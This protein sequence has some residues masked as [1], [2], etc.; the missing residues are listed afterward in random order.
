MHNIDPHGLQSFLTEGNEENEAEYGATS[1][2]V[3]FVAFCAGIRMDRMKGPRNTR[4]TRKGRTSPRCSDQRVIGVDSGALT[5][6]SVE[7]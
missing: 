6:L 7:S 4:N 2:S 3:P 5:W 1:V